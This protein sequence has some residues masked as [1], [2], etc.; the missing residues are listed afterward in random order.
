MTTTLRLNFPQPPATSRRLPR[1]TRHGNCIDRSNSAKLA[2]IRAI[3][4]PWHAIS[5]LVDAVVAGSVSRC[6]SAIDQA[7]V[8]FFCKRIPPTT[9]R[10][11]KIVV[12]NIRERLLTGRL[13]F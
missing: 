8:H 5:A 1:W 2:A 3:V 4:V 13:S 7:M 11:S 6:P 10:A 12:R 9:Y